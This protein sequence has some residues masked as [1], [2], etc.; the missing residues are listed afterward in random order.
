MRLASSILREGTDFPGDDGILPGLGSE[1]TDGGAENA[2]EGVESHTIS[3][4]S[5]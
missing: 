2:A 4:I 1:L 3:K 5:R